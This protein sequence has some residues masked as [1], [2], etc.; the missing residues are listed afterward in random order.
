M[1]FVSHH[2]RGDF[3]LLI[4][5]GCILAMRSVEIKRATPYDNQCYFNHAIVARVGDEDDAGGG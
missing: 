2:A 4:T 3:V 1:R 5:P